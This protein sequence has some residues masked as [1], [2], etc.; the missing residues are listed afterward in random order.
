MEYHLPR[1][2]PHDV[3]AA[4]DTCVRLSALALGPNLVGENGKAR[5]RLEAAFDIEAEIAPAIGLLHHSGNL[6]LLECA[7]H[8]GERR[9]ADVVEV[10]PVVVRARGP[11]ALLDGK[12]IVLNGH[13]TA[14]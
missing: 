8:L 14:P 2:V 6:L 5:R 1:A 13:D 3:A 9:Q 10:L 7:H 11:K 12:Q 4:D